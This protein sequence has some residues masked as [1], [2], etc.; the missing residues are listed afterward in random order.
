[1]NIY[2]T[3]TSI[4]QRTITEK[5][6]YKSKPPKRSKENSGDYKLNVQKIK[7]RL[8]LFLLMKKATKAAYLYTISFP[9]KIP[10][11]IAY[12]CFNSFLTNARTRYGLENYLWVAERQ[13]ND[14]IHYHMFVGEY[15][16]VRSLN[17]AMKST[18]KTQYTK[19]QINKVQYESTLNYNGVHISKAE[20]GKALNFRK[21]KNKKLR[22]TIIRYITK[23]VVKAEVSSESKYTHLRWFN[24]RSFSRLELS[25]QVDDDEQVSLLFIEKYTN[26][27]KKFT[28]DGGITIFPFQDIPEK[29]PIFQ[30]YIEDNEEYFLG[31]IL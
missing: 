29:I 14:T 4:Q 1:M 3:P 31:R 22:K 11:D 10:D 15:M 17:N 6:N 13:K 5:Y 16:N 19:G 12:K 7:K 23:Y 18:F 24:S 21:I 2:I 8:W 9:K 25:R 27:E 26:I 30:K 28:I 20:N